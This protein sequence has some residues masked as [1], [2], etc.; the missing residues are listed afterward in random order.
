MKSY[1]D[2]LFT[3]KLISDEDTVLRARATFAPVHDRTAVVLLSGGLD[4]STILFKVIADGYRKILALSFDY[5]QRHKI[6]LKSASNLIA[7]V[8]ADYN[9]VTVSHRIIPVPT[10]GQ[11]GES[12]LTDKNIRVPKDQSVESMG[13]EIPVTYVPGRNFV[14]LA[15]ATSVAEAYK[16]DSIY[17]GVNSLDYSGYVDCRPEF[18]IAFQKAADYATRLGV[19]ALEKDEI[20]IEIRTPIID[21]SKAQIIKMGVLLGV[22]Y[23]LTHSCY[24]P[25]EVDGEPLACGRCDSCILRHKGFVEADVLDP[26]KY[27]ANTTF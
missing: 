21:L 10:L 13:K 20:A 26:T 4:S 15:I 11:N 2:D 23:Y 6:E 16:A 1:F 3:D 5:D 19:E 8:R 24:D 17:C 9:D 27:V 22:P 25:V 14:F 7:S 12:A 18:I